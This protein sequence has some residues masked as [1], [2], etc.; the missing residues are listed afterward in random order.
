MK[1]ELLF[2]SACPLKVS[3]IRPSEGLNHFH[4]NHPAEIHEVHIPVCLPLP[5]LF[6]PQLSLPFGLDQV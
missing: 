5:S 3:Q 6:F 4:T 2:S 1:Y